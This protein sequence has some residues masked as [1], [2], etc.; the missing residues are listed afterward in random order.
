M[1]VDKDNKPTSR[2]IIRNILLAIA[3]FAV[4]LVLTQMGLKA[5]TRHNQVIIV[6]DLTG[7]SVADAKIVAKR[8]HIRTEVVDSVYVKRIEKGNVFSQNPAAGKEVKKDRVIKLTINA[9]QTKMVKMPNLVGY[10]LRQA[11]TEIL[12]SGLSVGKLAYREDIATNNVL[13]QFIKGRYVAPGTEVEAE[14]PVDLLLGLS[15]DE[16]ETFIPYL[17]G[18]TLA[19]ARDNLFENSLNLG[20]VTYDETVES[21]QDSVSAI[22]YQQSPAYSPGAPVR[23]GATIHLKLTTSQA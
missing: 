14:T 21:Y 16:N 23:M 19:V 17:I 22:V 10:S 18:Y 7:L 2:W 3:F 1:E 15:P 11:K 4:L 20:N 8:N 12:S 6:P 9:H 5:I 13:D